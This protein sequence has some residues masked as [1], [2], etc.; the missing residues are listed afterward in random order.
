MSIS[1]S[2]GDCIWVKVWVSILIQISVLAR[3]LVS[4]GVR[5]VVLYLSIVANG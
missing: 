1:I 4:L 5:C 2:V 3:E